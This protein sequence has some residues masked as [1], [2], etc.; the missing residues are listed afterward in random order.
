MAGPVIV[1]PLDATAATDA[2]ATRMSRGVLH[3]L[4]SPSL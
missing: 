3:S 2:C 4:P 1:V